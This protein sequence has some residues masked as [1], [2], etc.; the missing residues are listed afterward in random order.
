MFPHVMNVFAVSSQAFQCLDFFV[1]PIG[2]YIVVNILSSEFLSHFIE[3]L[4]SLTKLMLPLI[5]LMH[6]PVIFVKSIC[7]DEELIVNRYLRL[8]LIIFLLTSGGALLLTI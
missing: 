1:I 5:I 7:K 4:V 8:W 6:S 3:L 2:I